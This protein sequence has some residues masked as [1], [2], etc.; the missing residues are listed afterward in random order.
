M[1]KAGDRWWP[2]FGSVYL[3]SA[4]KR[5]RGMRVIGPAWKRKEERRVA[6]APAATPRTPV[7]FSVQIVRPDD[8]ANDAASDAAHG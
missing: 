4:V 6:L 2:V 3:L 7:A 5:V 1:E 8:A